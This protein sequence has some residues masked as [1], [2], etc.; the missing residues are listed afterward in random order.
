MIKIDF[1]SCCIL[2]L[3]VFTFIVTSHFP[4]VAGGESAAQ[5]VDLGSGAGSP[6]RGGAG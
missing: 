1:D 6:G 3:L 4:A 5:V 2:L